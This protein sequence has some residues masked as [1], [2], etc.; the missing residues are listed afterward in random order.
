LIPVYYRGK[1]EDEDK[2]VWIK[3]DDIL[4]VKMVGEGRN[5]K[6][7]IHT[8]DG[9][10]YEPIDT[11]TKWHKLLEPHG[12]MR[13]ARDNTTNLN[14]VKDLQAYEQRVYFEKPF[15][16]NSLFVYASNACVRFVQ[17]ILKNREKENVPNP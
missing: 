9:S 1:H 2:I 5:G 10:V 13:L 11:I 16:K 3:P 7:S 14:H 17:R 4:T 8:V 15:N 12:F 6:T